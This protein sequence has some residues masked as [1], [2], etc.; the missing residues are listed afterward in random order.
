M[1]DETKTP[2]LLNAHLLFESVLSV[3]RAIDAI[4]AFD[5]IMVSLSPD[6]PGERSDEQQV[7]AALVESA[8]RLLGDVK[9]QLLPDVDLSDIPF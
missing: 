3:E 2:K 4:Q 1:S 5:W 6:N 8:G 9:A 7:R